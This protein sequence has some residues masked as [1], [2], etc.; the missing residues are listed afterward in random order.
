MENGGDKKTRFFHHSATVRGRNNGIRSLIVG[1]KVIEDPIL[2]RNSVVEFFNG[3]F[4]QENSLEAEEINLEFLKL[5]EG[6]RLALEKPFSEEEVWRAIVDS[7]SNKAPGPDVGKFPADYLV[8]PLGSKRNYVAMWEPIVRNFYNKLSGWKANSL[9]LAG[10]VVLIKSVLSSLPTYFLSLFRIPVSFSSEKDSWWKRVVCCVNNLDLNSKMLESSLTA[11]ASWI[12]RGVI[13]NFFSNDGFGD[14]IRSNLRWKTG[15]GHSV[16]FW[17][18][19]WLGEDP[20]KDL[21]PRLYALSTN[22]EGKVVEF[23]DD[24]DAGWVWDIQFRRNLVDWEIEQWLQLISVLNNTSLSHD[25]EDRWIWLGN[26]EGC[27]STNSCIKI[28]FDSDGIEGNQDFL[29]RN[30]WV[31]IAPPRVETFLWQVVQQRVA[32]KE[33]LLKRGVDDRIWQWNNGC[34]DAENLQD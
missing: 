11:R 1:N 20:L 24:H 5:S 14:Y 17:K 6:Q 34:S 21:F 33:E 3:L 27:F 30:I 16:V 9:A 29:D 7:D 12:W 19:A 2:I 13:N 31:G 26:G 22:K 15:N 28:F 10:R 32:V 25:E 4:S 23:R 8:L 18:D